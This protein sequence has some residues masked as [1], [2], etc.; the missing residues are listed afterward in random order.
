MVR[1][2]RHAAVAACTA[3]LASVSCNRPAHHH[4][5]SAEPSPLA[6]TIRVAGSSFDGNAWPAESIPT[7][8]QG[9]VLRVDFPSE[10]D[11]SGR[12]RPTRE[13]YLLVNMIAKTTTLVMPDRK[14]YWETRFDTVATRRKQPTSVVGDIEVSGRLIASG[15]TVNGYTTNRYRITT[16]YTE[17][18]LDTSAGYARKSVQVEEDVWVTSAFKDVVDPIRAY[19]RALRPPSARDDSHVT[20]DAVVEKQA[21]ARRKLF[22]GMPI[23]TTWVYTHTFDGRWTAS[24]TATIDLLDL[25]RAD[26]DPAAFRVPD[27]Y[28]RFDLTAALK[29][30]AELLLQGGTMKKEP[31]KDRKTP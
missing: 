13:F 12:H 15:E 10:P 8:V 14:L 3:L 19:L 5:R 18:P 1:T 4:A 11:P 28:G 24:R 17:T 27:D 16:R 26:L 31:P 9:A 20:I 29:N 22:T 25:K 7:K 23:R 21:S 30:A 6:F 2:V